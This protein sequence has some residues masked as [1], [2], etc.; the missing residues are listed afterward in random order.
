[1]PDS[2]DKAAQDFIDGLALI[3]ESESR[4]KVHRFT[5]SIKL[6]RRYLAIEAADGFTYG[7]QVDVIPIGE[8]DAKAT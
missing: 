3:F 6:G 4:N 2:R 8:S 7:I 1:M 5:P